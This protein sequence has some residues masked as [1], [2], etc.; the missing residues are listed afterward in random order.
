LTQEQPFLEQFKTLIQ[1]D[2]VKDHH[3]PSVHVLLKKNFHHVEQ[4]INKY[5]RSKLDVS[6]WIYY[7]C[8]LNEYELVLLTDNRFESM[9]TLLK[10][11]KREL[12]KEIEEGLDGIV[13][14][15]VVDVILLEYI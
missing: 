10:D 13:T 6:W 3:H 5:L 15:Q 1:F 2:L 4:M 12:K 11:Y 9:I 7:S 8:F 14:K